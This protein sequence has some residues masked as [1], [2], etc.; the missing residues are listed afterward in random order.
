MA[1][2][3]IEIENEEEWLRFRGSQGLGASE[4]ATLLGYNPMKSP[5][6]LFHDKLG[7]RIK[8]FFNLR[9]AY[10]KASEQLNSDLVEAY[11][12]DPKTHA[13]NL[14]NGLKFRECI[15]LPQ[16]AFVVND[17]I[18]NAFFSPDREIIINGRS[19][20]LECKDTSSMYVNAFEGKLPP[21]HEIQLRS[22][23][24]GWDKPYGIVSHILDGGRD[25]RE[26]YFERDGFIFKDK[27]TGQWFSEEDVKGIIADF[28]AG[29]VLAREAMHNKE[30]AELNFNMSAAAKYQSIIDQ[31]EPEPD[32]SLAYENYVKENYYALAKPKIEIVGTQEHIDI[33]KKFLAEKEN[34]DRAK[35]NYQ[36]MKNTVLDICKQGHKITFPGGSIEVNRTK[37]GST[38]KVKA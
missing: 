5:F 37:V 16:H 25:Y 27:F 8:A 18:P 33:A 3:L 14:K 15:K 36:L 28:W 34:F 21:M 30:Q 24:W 17:E 35:D 9:M 11:N 7:F 10:G 13:M 31:C 1:V 19:G 12:G 6:E 20:S 4:I 26:H 29:V 22:Q 32:D 38:I 2:K 23:L